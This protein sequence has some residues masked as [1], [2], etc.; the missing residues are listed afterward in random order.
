MDPKRDEDCYDACILSWMLGSSRGYDM[1]SRARGDSCS[2][3]W[4]G[5]SD[6][7]MTGRGYVGM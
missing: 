5:D 1:T 2:V 7:D 3:L 4:T 6:E